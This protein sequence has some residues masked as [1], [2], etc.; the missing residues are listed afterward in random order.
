MA[1]IIGVDGGG[2]K[3]RFC[4]LN[5]SNNERDEVR[6][7]ETNF[8]NIGVFETKENISLGLS[9]LL[10]KRN[11]EIKDI[12]YFV[13]GIAG[14]DTESDF[15][16]FKA[17]LKEIEIEKNYSVFNDAK[18]AFR[19]CSNKNGMIFISGTG[20]ICF[21]YNGEKEIRIGG[22][23]ARFSDFGSGYW[24]G[25]K[26]LT[27]FLLYLEDLHESDPIFE[28][29]K[30]EFIKDK[31][32]FEYVEDNFLDIKSTASITKFILSADSEYVNNLADE[33]SHTFY[34]LAI[35]LNKDFADEE[36]DLV[37]SGGVMKNEK[38]YTRIKNKIRN[39]DDLKNITVIL[40]DKESVEGSINLA[41]SFLK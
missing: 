12:A 38:I 11:L 30:N 9:E 34:K 28:K 7:G 23:G 22:W 15:I 36:I 19:A 8:K 16:T 25:K 2:T 20:S 18:I 17:I 32:P 41:L 10:E 13:F 26:F 4:L 31:N 21:S 39:N 29:F 6:T 1:Y 14:C 35:H 3:T 33:V 24:I 37:L 40:N 5:T 27:D